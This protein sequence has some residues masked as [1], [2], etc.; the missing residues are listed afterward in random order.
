[1]I[2][3]PQV[4]EAPAQLVAT[5]HIE[6]PRSKMQHVMGPAIGEAM[7]AVKTQGIGPV[8]PRLYARRALILSSAAIWS[9]IACVAAKPP[10]AN[11]RIGSAS[12]LGQ[13]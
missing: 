6:T 13:S 2:E 1:M 11:A 9:K 10:Y 4:V 5:L 3:T 7:A 8:G 12:K